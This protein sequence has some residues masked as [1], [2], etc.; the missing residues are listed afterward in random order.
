[1]INSNDIFKII[2]EGMEK[3]DREVSILFSKEGHVSVSVYPYP[4]E[5]LDISL[6]MEARSYLGNCLDMNIHLNPHEA[7]VNILRALACLDKFLK[8][9]REEH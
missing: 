5:E 1:M 7:S 3:R 4:P 2:N 8:M 6:I 9:C